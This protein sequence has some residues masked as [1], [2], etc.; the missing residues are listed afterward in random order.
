MADGR[1][2]SNRKVAISQRN[3]IWFWWNLVHKCR[4][5]TQWQSSDEIWEF[6]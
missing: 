6:L 2:M 4:L 5:G 3:I 1:H